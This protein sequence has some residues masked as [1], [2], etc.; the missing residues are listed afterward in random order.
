MN[1]LKIVLYVFFVS[2]FMSSCTPTYLTSTSPDETLILE[3]DLDDEGKPWYQVTWNGTPIVKQSYL[4]FDLKDQAPLKGNFKV[5]GEL[6]N[7]LNQ[8]WEQPWGE[9]K[10]VLDH[11]NELT[12]FLEEKDGAKR[13]MN[14]IFRLF[15]DGIGFRYEIPEQPNLKDFVIMNENTQFVLNDNHD[16][17]WIWADYNTYEKL[18][19]QTDVDSATWVATPVTFKTKDNLYIS[20][21]EAALTNYA[22]MTL[23]LDDNKKYTYNAA[24]VPWS[25]GDKVRATAP[26][27]TPWRTIQVGQKAAD[28]VNSNIIVNLNE[29]SKIKDPSWIQPMQYLGIWWEFHIGT[30]E[31]K[32]GPRQGATT[33][34]AKKYIDFASEN[35]IGGVVVEGWNSGWDKWGQKDAFDHI[36]PAKGYDLEEVANYAQDKGV[37]LIMHNETGGDIPAYEKYMDEAF[38]LYEK[39][40]IHALKTGYAGGIYPRGEHH[41]GQFMVNHYRKV[42]EKAAQHKIML[43]AHEPIKPTGIRRTWPNMMT[44]EGVRGM[45]WNGWS[46]GNPP[47]HTVTIPFTRML[48]GPVDYTPGIFDVKYENNPNRVAWNTTAEIM[49]EAR[50]HTTLV[51]QLALSIILYS[52]LQMA[53]DLVENYEKEMK[54]FQFLSSSTADWDESKMLAGEIGEFAITA[55]RTDKE[56]FLGAATDA[57]GRAVSVSLDFLEPN[58][59][60]KATIYAD[61]PGSTHL[62]EPTKYVI[63][64]K[65]VTSSEAMLIQMNAGG[66]TAIHFKIL[67]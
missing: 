47:N 5:V 15:N 7:T 17:W 53:A 14:I 1:K 52:P 61:A 25:N 13:K 39:L 55:R 54:A 8:T 19:N 10:K 43:D 16:A 6:R 58:K 26:M 59:L 49:N 20:L 4:G 56:W 36:T 18:Y 41:H 67:D 32:E 64:E 48:G 34:S 60:Y 45:E 40:G 30:K 29:P 24:L 42:V 46:D 23:K 31:W 37:Y 65:N 51:K 22:G 57:T 3:F 28:L 12:V 35:N 50:V 21:H 33:A 38:K 63:T 9:N 66:G 44:R 27:K 11:H 62:N 2:L